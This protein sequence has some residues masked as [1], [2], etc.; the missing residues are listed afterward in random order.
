MDT[1][2]K[3]ERLLELRGVKK[4]K[5]S[6]LV[7]GITGISVQAAGKWWKKGI[8]KPEF[9]NILAI[10]QYFRVD[11]QMLWDDDCDFDES[12]IVDG[13]RNGIYE[14]ID[15]LTNL[16]FGDEVEAHLTTLLQVAE[17]NKQSH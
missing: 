11:A 12:A 6:S 17:K 3:I 5:R 14:K 4:H 10:A 13:V 1:L 15:K 2:D 8:E 16:G 7:A 9:K